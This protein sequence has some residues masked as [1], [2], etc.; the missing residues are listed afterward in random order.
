[1][2]DPAYRIE[3]RDLSRE[4]MQYRVYDHFP[5]YPSSQQET[6]KAEI[7][8]RLFTVFSDGARHV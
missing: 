8:K 6:V 2:A 3:E 7:E 5:L 1:M 4:R